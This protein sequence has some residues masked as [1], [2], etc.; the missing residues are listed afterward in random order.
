MNLA[1]MSTPGLLKMH[2]AVREALEIDDT[3]HLSGLPKTYGVRDFADWRPWTDALE[4]ELDN[5]K[6]KYAKVAW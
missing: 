3:L 4:A 6:V 5:R 1:G 2:N